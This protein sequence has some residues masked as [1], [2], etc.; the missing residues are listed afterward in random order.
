VRFCDPHIG[1]VRS[2]C[3]DLGIESRISRDEA[4]L[5]ERLARRDPYDIDPLHQSLVAIRG[6]AEAIMRRNVTGAKVLGC[7]LCIW[8]DEAIRAGWIDNI[9]KSVRDLVNR[10]DA[11]KLADQERT[12]KAE[13]D[14][15]SL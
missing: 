6:L 11:E 15:R 12:V 10:R 13:E 7:P 5:R 3:C 2:M 4:H 14:Y 8:R 1:T 9:A